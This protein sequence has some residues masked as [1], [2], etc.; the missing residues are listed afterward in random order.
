MS[1]S[2]PHWRGLI[3][4]LLSGTVLPA[5]A[6]ELYLQHQQEPQW[7]SLNF[8]GG[9]LGVY[10]EGQYEKSIYNGAGSEN[11]SHLFIGPE[12]GLN[13]DGSIYHPNLAQF[14]LSSDGALGQGWDNSSG[15]KTS[16]FEYLGNALAS[17]DLLGNKPYATT[18]SAS[19]T[20]TYT[21][22][23]FFSQTTVDTYRYGF[24]TGYREGSS[25]FNLSYWHTEEDNSGLNNNFNLDQD[26]LSFDISKQRDAGSSRFFYGLNDFSQTGMGVQSTGIDQVW[27]VSDNETLG[28][29]KNMNLNSDASYSLLDSPGDSGDNINANVDLNIDHTPSLWSGYGVGYGQSTYSG[30]TSDNYYGN[31]SLRHQLYQSLTS[32]LNFSGQN[33]SSSGS[34]GS[35]DST[36][37]SA[38][39]GEDY[40]K[41]LST[42]GRLKIN[43][44]AGYSYSEVSQ[45]GSAIPINDQSYS[46]TGIGVQVP[47]LEPNV[48]PS[49]IIIYKDTSH[50]FLYPEAGNYAVTQNGQITYI[51]LVAGTLI[52][53]NT[54]VYIS[55][56]YSASGTGS[57]SYDTRNEVLQVRMDLWGGLLGLYGRVNAIQNSG[58]AGLVLNNLTSYAVGADTTWHFLRAGAEYD[59]YDSSL[60]TYDSARLYQNLS[61]RPSPVSQLSFGFAESWTTYSGNNASEQQ[62]YSF[63]NRYHRTLSR[64]WGFD[65]EDGVSQQSG[66]GTDQTLVTVRPGLEFAKGQFS[67]RIG[68]DFEYSRY[69]SA[70]TRYYQTFF[71][72]AK[73]SF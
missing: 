15:S 27:G 69:L 4:C 39:L 25:P 1:A 56:T 61:F 47:L 23:N 60:S 53:L 50:T 10:S 43:A 21:E 3:V 52:P 12:L 2:S 18:A 26:T 51:T 44:G 13:F 14:T 29:R 32:S 72:R 5:A 22:Y 71:L 30:D 46:F 62:M 8:I 41:H 45:S 9:S 42:W 48:N 35:S 36:S 28:R 34:G 55:Y 63:I 68:Y 67:L 31:A 57:G 40:T 49:S 16:D 17:F 70:E 59:V 65:I 37:Y 54:P 73:R 66:G 33:S 11:Y 58:T 7:L 19:M 6:Q 24:Q 20:H 38:S 64:N